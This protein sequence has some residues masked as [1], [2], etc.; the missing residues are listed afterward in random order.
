[1]QAPVCVCVVKTVLTG[2]GRR[3]FA[4]SCTLGMCTPVVTSV[5]CECVFGVGFLCRCGC[6]CNPQPTVGAAGAAELLSP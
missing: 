2:E 3:V 4:Y 1:M 6:V 5:M